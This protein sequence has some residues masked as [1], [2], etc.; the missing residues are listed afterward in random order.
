MQTSPRAFYAVFSL[1]RQG[2]SVLRSFFAHAF[3]PSRRRPET[4]DMTDVDYQELRGFTGWWS[5]AAKR[6]QR[7]S[8]DHHFMRSLSIKFSLSQC[9]ACDRQSSWDLHAPS[10]LSL[11]I[12]DFVKMALNGAK[13]KRNVLNSHIIFKQDSSG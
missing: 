9:E 8:M 7:Y 11:G 2:F 3:D 13:D 12:S 1:E 10:S 6:D 5:L 4:H